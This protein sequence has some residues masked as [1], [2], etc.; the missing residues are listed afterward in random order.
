MFKFLQNFLNFSQSKLPPAS[1]VNFLGNLYSEKM[2]QHAS[3]KPSTNKC[4]VF[5][6]LGTCCDHLQCKDRKLVYKDYS[7]WFSQY[8]MVNDSF[9]E[10]HLLKFKTLRTISYIIF[11]INIHVIQQIY[12]SSSSLVVSIPMWLLC[13]C[14]SACFCKSFGFLMHL[15]FIITQSITARSSLNVTYGPS[16]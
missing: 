15:P 5:L 11:N 2:T 7:P 6:G 4:A 9:F 8:L 3:I 13:I 1:D 10:M 16:S 12:L 14:S